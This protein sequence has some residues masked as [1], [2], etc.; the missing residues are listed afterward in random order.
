M[1]DL[2]NPID[3]LG[4]ACA[5]ALRQYGWLSFLETSAPHLL[6]DTFRPDRWWKLIDLHRAPALAERFDRELSRPLLA[7]RPPRGSS[8][9]APWNAWL[10]ALPWS[11]LPAWSDPIAQ[12]EA[13]PARP[14]LIEADRALAVRAVRAIGVRTVHTGR[15]FLAQRV[16]GFSS[17]PAVLDVQTC[18]LRAPD[19][20]VDSVGAPATHPL[21]PS[22]CGRLAREGRA[23]L[24]GHLG[25]RWDAPERSS[26]KKVPVRSK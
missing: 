17:V 26:I 11:A 3:G 9:V 6:A 24:H 4:P 1:V 20:A 21:P 15:S 5:S 16:P 8:L 22:L 13:D 7:A 18:L 23:E 25:D 10:D 2:M 19:L 12:T 14:W